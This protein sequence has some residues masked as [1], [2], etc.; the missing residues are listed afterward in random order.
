MVRIAQSLSTPRPAAPG[1][2]GRQLRMEG[3]G[4]DSTALARRVHRRTDSACHMHAKLA[5]G[6]ALVLRPL[7]AGEVEILNDVFAGMSPGSRQQRYLVAM[8]RLTSDV[9]RELTNVDDRDHVAWV[10]LV[11]GSP[12]GICRY[13]RTA[14]DAAELALEVVDDAQGRGIGAALVDSVTTVA[15]FNGVAW[16]EAVVAPGNR[17][18][19]SLLTQVGVRFALDDGLLVGR[20]R[21]RLLGP[22]SRVNRHAVLVLAA[23]A[24][25]HASEAAV[26]AGVR[27]TSAVSNESGEGGGALCATTS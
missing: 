3:E 24:A 13:V 19:L 4:P 23:Q 8:P 10:A 11:G 16:L 2:E 18:S 21:L 6:M 25:C 26:D 27:R 15:Q 20:G 17:A 14:D 7:R 9:Q 22:P 5:D 1:P 12:A